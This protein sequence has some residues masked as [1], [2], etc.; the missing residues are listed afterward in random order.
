MPACLPPEGGLPPPVV[1]IY[2]VL[3]GGEEKS[4]F[5]PEGRDFAKDEIGGTKSRPGT[6]SQGRKNLVPGRRT[7]SEGRNSTQGR[8]R[9]NEKISSQERNTTSEGRN[10]T[11]ERNHRNVGISFLGRGRIII[12]RNYTYCRIESTRSEMKSS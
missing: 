7:K 12:Q 1:N 8:N 4:S 6:K 10:S 5:V 3:Q 11:Q 2:G 9:R